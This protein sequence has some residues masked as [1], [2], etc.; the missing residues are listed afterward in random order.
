MTLALLAAAL[1]AA[2]VPGPYN[3]VI[4]WGDGAP[5]VVHYIDQARCEA[6]AVTVFAQRDPVVDGNGKI[7]PVPR[8]TAGA[9]APYAFCIPG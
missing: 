7:R 1:T 8:E 5:V 9:N 6:A 3:L 4:R 2:G